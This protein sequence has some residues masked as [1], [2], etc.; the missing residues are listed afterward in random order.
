MY[1]HIINFAKALSFRHI[2]EEICEELVNLFKD[3]Y[4]SS[5]IL[6]VYENILYLSITN[7]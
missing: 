5:S 2:K 7:E 6:Y 1:N 3:E 4:L